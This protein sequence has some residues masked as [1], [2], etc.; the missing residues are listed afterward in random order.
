MKESRGVWFSVK[1]HIFPSSIFI[2]STFVTVN[3]VLTFL[4]QSS[5]RY[6]FLFGEGKRGG[7]VC[8]CSLCLF[9]LLWGK[10][11]NK[12]LLIVIAQSLGH[13]RIF[14]ILVL[15]FTT[16]LEFPICS[17]SPTQTCASFLFPHSNRNYRSW[18]RKG[19]S[20]SSRRY[21]HSTTTTC[22]G[23]LILASQQSAEFPE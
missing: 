5:C 4:K 15:P 10:L 2:Y 19:S 21:C 17:C 22:I 6:V 12:C 16:A 7:E 11:T 20:L 1:K 14:S 23:Y 8:F 13:L 9:C 3:T 18:K